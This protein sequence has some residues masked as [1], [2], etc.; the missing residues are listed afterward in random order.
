MQKHTWPHSLSLLPAI[1]RSLFNQMRWDLGTYIFTFPRVIQMQCPE[2]CL[3]R[4]G[5]DKAGPLAR[6]QRRSQRS[7]QHCNSFL[8]LR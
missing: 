2:D 3:L 7:Q 8:A 1:L 6:W 4:K 5:Q